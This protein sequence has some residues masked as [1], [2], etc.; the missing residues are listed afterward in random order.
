MSILSKLSTRE[1]QVFLAIAA[2][3]SPAK[4]AGRLLL[5]VKTVSTYRARV[6]EKL[7]V[8]AGLSSNGRKLPAAPFRWSATLVWTIP[9]S[10]T[11][12]RTSGRSGRSPPQ[13]RQ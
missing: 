7:K 12:D 4:I 8:R 3:E 2:G 13:P 10:R 6:L 9:A 1:G 11:V 5:S